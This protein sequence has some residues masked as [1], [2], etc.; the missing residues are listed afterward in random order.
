M[1][2]EKH[3]RKL[4]QKFIDKEYHLVE[5]QRRIETANFPDELSDLKQQ[6]L[7]ELEEIRFTKLEDNFYQYGLEVVDKLLQQIT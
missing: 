3:L 4:C 6:V 2:N 1:E 5:F 7:N